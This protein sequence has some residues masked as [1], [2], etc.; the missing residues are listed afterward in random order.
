MSWGVDRRMGPLSNIHVLKWAG[1]FNEEGGAQ[2]IAHNCLE[3][4]AIPAGL[5]RRMGRLE[6]LACRC[7]LSVLEEGEADDIVFC[8]RYGNLET[9]L[10]LLRAIANEELL[11]PMAFS[12]SVHNAA[13]GLVGQITRQRASHTAVAAGPDTLEM[14]ILESYARLAS[15]TCANVTLVYAETPLPDVFREFDEEVRCSLA[16]GM[17]LGL[18]PSSGPRQTK[19]IGCGPGWNGALHF[20]HEL[21]AGRTLVSVM[22]SHRLSAATC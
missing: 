9:L 20:F 15:N 18:A 17:R 19:P 8:S 10:V 14:G 11:S 13:P 21:A 6:R 22:E 7:A 12:G 3:E 1:L 16:F 4:S 2:A 5:R